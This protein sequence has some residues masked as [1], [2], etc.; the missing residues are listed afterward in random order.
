MPEPRRLV[1]DDEDPLAVRS[2]VLFR[3]F[4]WYLRWYFWQGF[5]AVRMSRTGLP[6]FPENRPVI[7]YTNHSSWWDPALFILLSAKLMPDRLSFGPMEAKSLERYALLRRFGVFGVDVDQPRGAARFLNVSQ[8]VLSHPA[9]ALWITAEGSFTD[10]RLRPVRLRAGPAHLARRVD[11]AVLIPVAVEYTFWNERKPEVLLRFGTP[12]EA[13][14]D[15]S[16]ADWTVLLEREL[17]ASMDVLAAE[18][19]TRDPALFVPLLSGTSGVGGIYDIWR[20]LK[21]WSR[22]RRAQLSHEVPRRDGAR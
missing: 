5:D 13:S 20:R 19:A 16:V 3:M 6:A 8:R 12:L 2:P 14:R 21:A 10:P 9:S 11:R 18:S 7:L 1:G 15:R 22:G 17:T 4:S